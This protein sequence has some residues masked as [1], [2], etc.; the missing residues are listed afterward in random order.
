MCTSYRPAKRYEE[1]NK[2]G[3]SMVYVLT[4]LTKEMLVF[5]API[6]KMLFRIANREDPDQTVC[7]RL[8]GRQLLFKILEHLAYDYL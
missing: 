8:F 4:F 7:L 6:H 5:R 3:K 1:V 2:V